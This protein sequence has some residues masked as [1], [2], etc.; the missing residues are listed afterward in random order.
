VVDAFFLA[1]READFDA[2]VAVLDPGVV[3]RIDAGPRRPASMSVTG[4][5]AVARQ[6][7]TGLSSALRVARLHPALVNG[8]V[9]VVVTVRGRPLTV[10][11]FAVSG[12]KIPAIDAIAD[13]DRVPGIASA[14][15]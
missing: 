9:G 12:G 2:L 3:L 5:E 15:G 14:L 4:A 8:A 11:G 7:L 13:P 6:A 10:I 1:A